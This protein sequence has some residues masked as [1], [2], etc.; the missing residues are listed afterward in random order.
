MGRKTLYL[1]DLAVFI[2]GSVLQFFVANPWQLFVVRLIMG[3]AIGADYAVG[4]GVPLGVSCRSASGPW[5]SPA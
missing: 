5:C 3:I 1:V 2:V 4:A